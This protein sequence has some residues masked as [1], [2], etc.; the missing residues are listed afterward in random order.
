M[1]SSE[2]AWKELHGLRENFKELREGVE[3]L[4]RERG[5]GNANSA[6]S[7]L[8]VN[9]GGVGMWVAV[10][11]SL[12]AAAVMLGVNIG[13][14]VM[15]NNHDRKIERLQDYLQVVYTHAPHLKEIADEEARKK[16]SQ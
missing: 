10:S 1:D 15:V 5:L 8:T 11:L 4:I 2:E 14:A 7:T 6:A 16:D 9:A 13:L 3:G 12:L